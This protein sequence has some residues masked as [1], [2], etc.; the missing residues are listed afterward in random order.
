[1]KKEP[2]KLRE[3]PW[4]R[5]L[6]AVL[7]TA[8]FICTAGAQA[9]PKAQPTPTNPPPKTKAA[10]AEHRITPEEAREL[11]NSVDEVLKF[12]SQ[13]SL[14][15]IKHTVKRQ[16]ADR[17]QVQKYIEDNIKSDA[18]TQRL[19]KAQAVLKKFGMLPRNFDLESFL[20]ELMR[21][22]VAGYYDFKTKTVNLLDWLSP[23]QQLP[24]MA[25]ELT[26]AL[27][28]QS[29]GLEKWIKAGASDQT[30]AQE[31]ESD[32]E[33]AAR[34]AVIEGQA[35][36]VMIDYLLA[37]TGNTVANSPMITRAIVQ[38]MMAGSDS[39][40]F[41]RA[42]LYIKRVLM[43]PYSYGLDFE[44]ELLVTGGKERA[45]EGVLKQPPR[46][47]R[48]VMEPATYL[49]GEK[50]AALPLP[51]FKK[52]LS[53][54][55]EK[56]DVGSV[57]EFD[58]SAL[59]EQFAGE[60]QAKKIYPQWRGGYYYA[61]KK[62][63]APDQPLGLVFVTRWASPQAAEDFAGIYG[64]SVRKRYT[65]TAANGNTWATSEGPVSLSRQ[66]EMVVSLESLD[67]AA[68]DKVREAVMQSLPGTSKLVWPGSPARVHGAKTRATED[69][70]HSP[71]ATGH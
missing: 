20:I 49:A 62:K 53:A 29:V 19:K 64:G 12:D 57:G 38:S 15:P 45:F 3:N 31:V 37:P 69:Q 32:E 11:L 56:Y 27:Q 59:V 25:H 61:A 39:P 8:A 55:W 66:G 65:V 60:E 46:N 70:L 7:V 22:Q 14:L 67:P 23:E 2:A 16:L 5:F 6:A 41:N 17:E 42:P 48:Q 21:E 50:L 30:A 36:A 28:D 10:P 71:P 4:L 24:V 43:F 9:P 33:L 1:M 51:D 18:D 47:T 54:E 58:V 40:V 26:H 63:D 44:R 13:A 68:A 35:M 52:L 34:H